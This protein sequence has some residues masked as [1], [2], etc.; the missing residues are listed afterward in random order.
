MGY[1]TN[2]SGEFNLDKPLTVAHKAYL[3]AFASSRR[4]IRNAKLTEKRSDPI[5]EAVGLPVGEDGGYFVGEGGFHGQDDGEDVVNHNS[6]PTDQPGLWCQWVPNELGTAIVWDEGEKFYEYIDW[7]EYLIQHFLAPWGYTLNG[8]VAWYGE[9]NSDQGVI[10]V[11][12]N[13]IQAIAAM[14]VQDEPDWE[15]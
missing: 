7:L 12:N 13:K 5:R 2:F 15:D 11:K 6:P 4:M 1:D 9:E 8:K 3:E 10:Y 14:I